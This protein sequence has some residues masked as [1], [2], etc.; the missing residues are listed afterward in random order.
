MIKRHRNLL[1]LSLLS[2][3][4]G[5]AGY[6]EPPDYEAIRQRRLARVR[7]DLLAEGLTEDEATAE[8]ERLDR[9]AIEAI[10][11]AMAAIRSI[12]EVSADGISGGPR[13]V[14]VAPIDW[15]APP[16]PVATA[17]AVERKPAGPSA[18]EINRKRREAGTL[19]T[20]RQRM[21]RKGWAP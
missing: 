12:R 1:G 9:E 5:A 6:T 19:G 18:A 13:E 7:A 10:G 20:K 4:L 16:A 8:L 2:L 15:S 3:A 14:Q 17:A 11:G 21:A